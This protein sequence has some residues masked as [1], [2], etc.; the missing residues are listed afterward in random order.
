MHAGPFPLSGYIPYSHIM[1][2][3]RASTAVLNPSL[4]EGWSTTVEEAKALGVPLLL[5]DLRVHRE[6]APAGT[7]FF[8]PD[9]AEEMAAVLEEAWFSLPP[10]PRYETER[11]AVATYQLQRVEFARRFIDVAR[12]AVACHV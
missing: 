8:D 3:M 4:F 5:S 9:S 1:P 11:Q 6:Q 12:G 10:G 2:L 7:R